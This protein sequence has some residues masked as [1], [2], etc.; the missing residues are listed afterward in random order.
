MESP[1]LTYQSYTVLVQI[2]YT[3]KPADD[4]HQR[5]L[6]KVVISD[7]RSCCVVTMRITK[8]H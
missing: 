8:D 4:D 1:P 5:S 7:R 2:A 3:V 6:T